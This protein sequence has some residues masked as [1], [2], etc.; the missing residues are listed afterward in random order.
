VTNSKPKVSIVG[1]QIS[2]M[3]LEVAIVQYKTEY[4]SF[5]ARPI[6]LAD[7]SHIS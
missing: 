7:G 3:G 1:I 5:N 4:V 2:V 6:L